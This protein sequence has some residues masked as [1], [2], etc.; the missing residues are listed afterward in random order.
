MANKCYICKNRFGIIDSQCKGKD[1]KKL[2]LDLPFEDEI[3]NEMSNKDAF[4][5]DCAKK[6]DLKHAL[7]FYNYQKSILSEEE[8]QIMLSDPNNHDIV[9]EANL[10]LSKISQKHSESNSSGATLE[11][12]SNTNSGGAM[13]Q[14]PSRS[15]NGIFSEERNTPKSSQPNF[16]NITSA[17][18]LRALTQTLHNQT[19]SQWDKNGVV[20]YKDNKIAILKRVVGQQVQ[21]I[22]ACSKVTE[23][24]YRLMSVDEGVTAQGSGF[25]GGASAYFY[26]QKMDYVR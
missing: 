9:E 20:Q 22:V 2:Y 21:F 25:T 26:F 19:K 24:G 7:N 17:T 8:F 13:P 10:Q 3:V 18:Q 11:S 15:P 1:L 12:S 16:S 23:E 6:Q 4:C 5:L 14:A